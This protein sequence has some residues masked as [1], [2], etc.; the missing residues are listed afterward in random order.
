MRTRSHAAFAMAVAL[1]AV[2]L[3]VWPAAHAQ[4]N[5][6][7]IAFVYGGG[8]STGPFEIRRAVDTDLVDLT[9][10]AP[11]ATGEPLRVD[12]RLETFD[13]VFVDGSTPGLADHVG[14]LEAAAK[15]TR[16]V[17]VKPESVP[18]GNVDLTRFPDIE[19]YW[20][21][22][23][24]DN[25]RHLVRYLVR[26]VLARASAPEP[27]PP[28]SYPRLGYYHP[29][30]PRLFTS[31]DEAIA[32]N[33]FA[34]PSA[35]DAVTIGLTVSMSSFFQKNLAHIDAMIEAIERRGHRAITMTYRSAPDPGAFLQG[36]ESAVDTVIQV[37][38]VFAVRD[39]QAFLDGLAAL[40]VPVLSAFHQHRLTEADYAASPT[41]LLPAL[42]SALV[43]AEQEGRIE[44]MAVSGRGA[45]R[46]DTFFTEPYR[47]VLQWRIDR[48]VA[49]ARL[50][51]MLNHSKR[52]FFTYW[53]QGGGKANVGG[54]PDDFLDVPGTMAR[55]L[56]DMQ[57]RGYDVGAEPLPDAETLARRMALEGSNVG[58]W[59][60]GELSS[61]VARGLVRLVPEAQYL[62]WFN[63]LPS[64]RRDEIVK[65]WGPP[66]GAVGVHT[67]ARGQRSLVVPGLQF[68][69]V[70]FA[71]NPDWGYLQ[72]STVL[73]S[74]GALPPH[75]QYL[76]FFLW[77]QREWHADAWVSF[78]SNISLQNGKPVGPMPDE[79]IGILLGNIPHIHPERLGANGGLKT[80]RKALAQTVSWY[81]IVRPSGAGLQYPALRSLLQRYASLEDEA[82]RDEMDRLIREEVR[83]GGLDRLIELDGAPLDTVV[84]T[85]QRELDRLDRQFV[86]AG[87][88][89]LGTA[90]AGDA[91]L[92]MLVAMLGAPFLDLLGGLSNE[93]RALARSLVT[94]VVDSGLTATDAVT[95]RLG[96]ANDRVAA[97]LVP[98]AGYA[99][100][101]AAA[102]RE[103]DGLFAALDGRWIPPGSMDD[104][105]RR[106][107]A[108]PPGRSVYNFD[109]AE[110]PTVEAEALGAKQADA[111]IAAH[112]E[113]H[114]G[115]FPTSMAFAIFSGEVARNRGVTEAQIL[116]LLGTRAVRDSRGFVTGV[117]LIPR[118][119]LGRPR[120][121]IM[122]TTSGT[123]RDHYPDVMALIARATQ[124]AATSPEPDNPVRQAMTDAETT[125][126]EQ[127]ASAARAAALA[128]ARVFA[129]APGAYSPNVQFLAK[130]GDQ[131]GDEKK[132]AELY[133]S[134]LSHAYG[135]GLYGEAARPA[136]EQQLARVDAATFTRSSLVNGMLDNPM[137]AGF[138]GGLNLAA[139][140][141]T[142]RDIDLYVSNLRDAEKPTLETASAE[143]Q[144]ELRTRYFNRSWVAEMQAHGYDGARNFMYL[145][146]HLDLWN[147]TAS[148]TVTSADWREVK[149][150]YV[151]DRMN[152]GMREFFDTHNPHAQQVMLGNLLG[153]ASRGHWKATD[154]ERAEVATALAR[155]VAAHGIAC[156][157]N[158]CRNPAFT[159][160]VTQ[161]LAS[162]PDGAALAASYAEALASATTV[163]IPVPTS[164]ASSAGAADN[165]AGLTAP[166]RGSPAPAP[167][168]T[169]LPAPAASSSVVTGRVMEPVS[170]TGASDSARANHVGPRLP[171]LAFTAMA[172]LLAGWWREGRTA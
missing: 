45:E 1:V 94:D 88:K 31:I 17:V 76:A 62:D 10:F 79:H 73:M 53:S 48:A 11:G 96:H 77:M 115:A 110:V 47:D 40:D 109:S 57:A 125:L 118:D 12:T 121:D 28:I 164:A 144:R 87:S 155:S 66:P 75:H 154:I 90:A 138:L 2:A 116:H 120:V 161:T 156:E 23:S 63:A 80:K 67:D 37:G 52:V 103:I 22:P 39:R 163:P 32:F 141:V 171:V 127:G 148:A 24:Q 113:R 111:L 140:A 149:E 68:G 56:R 9:V 6:P 134:R 172:L 43:D 30:A 153:A 85:V 72:D 128:R 152:L 114:E 41:G 139:K 44:P 101:L 46:G 93:H 165:A 89:V 64:E 105:L 51:R 60:P 159:E 102:P 26:D 49:W 135:E 21:N 124:V 160:M 42:G 14:Q 83:A 129:P 145:T 71:P 106:P 107:D 35:A 69:N 150:V 92:D 54:D 98:V 91:R 78:F 29:R 15:A 112:R 137:P 147:S 3:M 123:Y 108:L 169:P 65:T 7:R 142:G 146:D 130:S 82:L 84:T 20:S 95:A 162:V 170:D 16:V 13:L 74:S 117:E 34:G 168:V 5:R 122:L 167:A 143:I 27:A 136:F 166:G 97:A 86:P 131:R 59:A 151:D 104:P 126:L 157:A 158:L 100:N 36:A 58:N 38:S 33:R 81:S 99:A 70:M 132:M 18:P 55:L 50:R 19:R 119:E 133:T 25:Y 61:R 8:E 4:T